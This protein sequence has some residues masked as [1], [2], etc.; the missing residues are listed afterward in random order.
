[1]VWWHYAENPFRR[2]PLRRTAIMHEWT[3]RR[4]AKP[5]CMAA[6]HRTTSQ[7]Q[8]KVYYNYK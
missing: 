3:L 1:M 5:G 8:N 7:K 6:I 4:I 2:M